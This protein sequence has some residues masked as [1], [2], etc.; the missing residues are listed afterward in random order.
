VNRDFYISQEEFEAIEGYIL[1]Q[2]SVEETEAFTKKLN[3]D[4]ALQ[5]KL[6]T[7]KLLLVG[8]QEAEL[9]KKLDEF[10]NGLVS[11]KKNRIEPPT[12]TFAIKKWLV[13]ASV[14]VIA[15]VGSLLFF[16]KETKE[17][18]IF[19]AYFQPEP[20]LISAMSTTDSYLFDR[21]MIDY[22]TGEYD[23]ALK[24]WESLLASNP[25][26][27]TLNYFI[28]SVYL[29]REKEDIAIDYFKKV[30]SNE[31]SFFRN[32]A[33]WYTGLALLKTNKKPEAVGFIEKAEHE[34]KAALLKELKN[35]D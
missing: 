13:A 23:A 26:N 31:N 21:A 33:L 7:V 11:T 25:K 16:N 8:I 27:D 24:T 2:M 4:L 12:K 18:K 28:G 1:Q 20:G 17:E 6:E 30:I 19:A 22:K 10:H 15:C 34:Y 32:E 29:I 9:Q 5:H 3:T 14:I 35:S